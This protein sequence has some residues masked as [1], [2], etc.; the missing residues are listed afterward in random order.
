MEKW[1]RIMVLQPVLYFMAQIQIYSSSQIK[2]ITCS[3]HTTL[4]SCIWKLHVL[5]PPRP[6]LTVHLTH[7]YFSLFSKYRKSFT[8][9]HLLFISVTPQIMAWFY[10]YVRTSYELPA[11]IWRQFEFFWRQL[12]WD[13]KYCFIPFSPDSLK[14]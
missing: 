5:F 11:W 9:E 12:R 10:R 4:I 2:W 7:M 1:A 8:Q 3:Q 13:N 6:P 14:Y